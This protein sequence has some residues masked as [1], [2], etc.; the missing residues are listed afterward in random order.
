M[1]HDTLQFLPATH[2]KFPQWC[3]SRYLALEKKSR[4]LDD[5]NITMKTQTLL[6]TRSGSPKGSDLWSYEQE[7]NQVA[8]YSRYGA[9]FGNLHLEAVVT[10]E[11]DASRLIRLPFKK[12]SMPYVQFPQT[13]EIRS[14]D[15]TRPY[16][17]RSGTS[18]LPFWLWQ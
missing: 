4:Q 9:H 16:R 1:F 12:I 10:P 8:K 13:I 11:H 6:W 17:P 15:A 2:S 3:S 14:R 18:P 7:H 5:M